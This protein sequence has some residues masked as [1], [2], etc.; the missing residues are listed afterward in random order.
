MLTI[1]RGTIPRSCAGFAA[2]SEATL[3]D[4]I[5]RGRALP[6]A[7]ASGRFRPGVIT[8]GAQWLLP[9]LRAYGGIQVAEARST[10]TNGTLGRLGSL[11]VRLAHKAGEVRRAQKLRYRVFY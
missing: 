2:G 5:H 9:A 10:G 7:Q 4:V 3:G 6:G 11:E 1:R 8:P